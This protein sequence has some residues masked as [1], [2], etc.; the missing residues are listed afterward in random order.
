ME[1]RKRYIYIYIKNLVCII[2]ANNIITI[3]SKSYIT[4][5]C[6]QVL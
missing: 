2:Y 5:V 3:Y 6:P 1:E 4:I